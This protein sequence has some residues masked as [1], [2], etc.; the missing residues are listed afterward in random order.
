MSINSKTFWEIADLLIKVDSNGIRKYSIDEIAIMTNTSAD[1]V[2]YI[3][4]V[5]NVC[6]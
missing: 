3:D 2:E 1:I 6:L 4:L 5:E